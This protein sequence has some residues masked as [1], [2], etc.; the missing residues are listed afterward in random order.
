M[1]LSPGDKAPA[2]SLSDQSGNTVKL[3]DFKGRKVL[4]FFYPQTLTTCHI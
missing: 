4:V 1:A 2:I 3:S